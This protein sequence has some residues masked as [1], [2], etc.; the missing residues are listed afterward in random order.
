MM[1]NLLLLFALASTSMAAAGPA[2]PDFSG[3]WQFDAAKSSQNT[4]WIAENTLLITQSGD[5]LYMTRMA[6]ENEIWRGAYITDGKARPLYK[7]ANEEA[8]ITA[9]WMKKELL[10]IV[11]HS[12]RGELADS[13]MKD[14][15]RWMLADTGQTLIHKT[16]D[17]KTLTFHKLPTEKSS[18]GAAH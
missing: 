13:S 6:G 14:E 1:R 2:R 17:G 4:D 8:F 18:S 15:D 9:R 10:V 12:M 3:N 7:N 11:E 5:R 16:S